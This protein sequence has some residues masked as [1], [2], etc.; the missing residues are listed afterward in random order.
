MYLRAGETVVVKDL[1][2]LV[3]ASVE[4]VVKIVGDCNIHFFKPRR[5]Y[6]LGKALSFQLVQLECDLCFHICFLTF[7]YSSLN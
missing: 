4:I 7:I 6:Q 3:N 5:L 1:S 2:N